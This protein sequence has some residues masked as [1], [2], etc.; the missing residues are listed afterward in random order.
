[1]EYASKVVEE[2][3]ASGIRIDVDDRNETMGTKIRDASK[4]W[5]PFIAVAGDKEVKDN[6]LHVTVRSSGEKTNMTASQIVAEILPQLERKPSRPLP[7]PKRVSARP[8][9]VG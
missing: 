2:N 3:A 8:K 4:E 9:F 1:L 6:N 7:L 5:I